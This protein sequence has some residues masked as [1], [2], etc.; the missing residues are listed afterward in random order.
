M[1][2]PQSLVHQPL[3]LSRKLSM[4]D[5]ARI[6]NDT[7]VRVECGAHVNTTETERYQSTEWQSNEHCTLADSATNYSH[8]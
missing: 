6:I 4:L 2:P 8:G 1:L 7:D 5:D 3:P